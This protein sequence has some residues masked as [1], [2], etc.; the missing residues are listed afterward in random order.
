LPYQEWGFASDGTLWCE[1]CWTGVLADI[2]FVGVGC[3]A[4]G[5]FT[6]IT[7][8]GI[9]RPLPIAVY[10]A[11]FTW[12][13]MEVWLYGRPALFV[14][15]PHT[16]DAAMRQMPTASL[17]FPFS[18]MRPIRLWSRSAVPADIVIGIAGW[19]LLYRLS[20]SPMRPR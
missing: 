14:A 7:I 10:S 18:Y 6:R 13:N 2:V 12:L 3:F 8:A 5:Y 15:T 1:L 16:M 9:F 11:V 17:G 20:Q 4:I 19:L